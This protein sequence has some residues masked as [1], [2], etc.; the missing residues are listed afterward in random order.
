MCIRDRL[1]GPLLAQSSAQEPSMIG[2]LIVDDVLIEGNRVSGMARPFLSEGRA[3]ALEMGCEI[4]GEGLWGGQRRSSSAS[5]P[6]SV[7]SSTVKSSM[8]AQGTRAADNAQ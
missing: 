1:G 6:T 7:N 3:F 8:H 4:T 2:T 5:F